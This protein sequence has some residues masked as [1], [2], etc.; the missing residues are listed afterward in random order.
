MRRYTP[1]RVV[2]AVFLSPLVIPLVAFG[3]GLVASWVGA[4]RLTEYS[5]ARLFTPASFAQGIGWIGVLAA[6]I[7][8]YSGVVLIVLPGWLLLRWFNRCSW[9]SLTFIGAAGGAAC[10]GVVG[11]IES[12]AL[13]GSDLL[14]C[15]I[16]GGAIAAV[17]NWIS[18][19]SKQK[20]AN[21]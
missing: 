13:T 3:I 15:A 5:F 8:G 6:L 18:K 19:Q 16:F 11:L 14:T 20:E 4:D 2:M 12:N 7:V 9:R 21:K 17:F 1:I 10:Y